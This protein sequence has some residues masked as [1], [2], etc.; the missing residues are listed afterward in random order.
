MDSAPLLQNADGLPAPNAMQDH[1][2]FLRACHSPWPCI[3]QNILVILRGLVL[4]F[5]IAV[6]ILVLVFEFNEISQYSKWRIIF[7]FANLSFFLIF[8][9]ELKAFSWTFTHLYYPHHHDRHMGGIEG[10]LIK[11]MS[12]PKHMGSLRKQFYFTMFYTIAAVFAFTNTTVYFFVTRNHKT[13]GAYGEPQPELNQAPNSTSVVWAG[14]AAEPAPDAPFTDIFGEGWFRAFIILALYTFG[15][16]IMVIEI[17]ILNCIRRPY[18]IGLHLLGIMFFAAAY[19]GWAAFGHL[20]TDFFPFFWLDKFEVGSDEAV[21]LYS[22]GF[23]FLTPIMYILMQGLISS[24]ENMTRSTAEA[25]A[26]AAAQA[27]LDS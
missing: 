17:V 2:A 3:P 24:R 18:T 15:S 4:A 7:D 12:L 1:P 27:A 9:Y 19:L 13:D 22:I 6:G 14:S 5:V 20:V 25:R 8:L 23:V 16:A 26:I 10:W 11:H 21:T